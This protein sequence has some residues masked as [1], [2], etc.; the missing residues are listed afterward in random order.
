M[1]MTLALILALTLL[2]PSMSGAQ[3]D[4]PNHVV[5]IIVPIPPG[6][7]A[8]TFPRLIAEKLSAQWKTPVVVENRPGAGL[9]IGAE[10]VSKAEPDG[11]IL[12]ATPPGPLVTSRFFYPRLGFDPAAFVPITILAK[13]PFVLVARRSLPVSS[14]GDLIAYAKMHPDKLN[15]ASAG[16]GTPPH[17][18]TEMLKMKAGIRLVHV[19]YKGLTPAL[20]DLIAGH[21]DMMFHDPS[22]T[23]PAIRAG[24]LRALGVGSEAS[25]PELPEVPP[26]AQTVAGFHATTWYALV[27]PPKTPDAIASKLSSAIG[28]VLQEPDVAKRLADFSIAAGGGTPVET[29]A[30]LR[31]E[32]KRWGEVVTAARIGHN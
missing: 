6:G 15:F 10:F 28:H 12:L 30:F 13:A 7:F 20:T 1:G 5:K 27:A 23:L 11:Y 4:Y 17:L 31:A 3:G 26:I 32:H 25:L 19:P 9:N 22:S 29:A 18:A 8:D 21:V 16:V 14:L 24:Q 2:A